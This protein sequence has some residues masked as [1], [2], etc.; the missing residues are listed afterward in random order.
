MPWS[1]PADT[2]LSALP[3]TASLTAYRQP[4]FLYLAFAA[5]FLSYFGAFYF[6][7]DLIRSKLAMARDTDLPAVPL[8]RELR[9]RPLRTR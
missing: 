5:L 7:V 9:R 6:L 1:R 3:Y 2:Y 8:L 4:A